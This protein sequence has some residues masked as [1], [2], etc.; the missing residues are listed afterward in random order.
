VEIIPEILIFLYELPSNI[1]A[2]QDLNISFT[3]RNKEF[4][5]SEIFP[6]TETYLLK[7]ISFNCIWFIYLFTLIEDIKNNNFFENLSV[8][9]YFIIR[10]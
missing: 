4:W 6:E 2:L 7:N 8:I 5:V 1:S 9:W 3:S 10:N